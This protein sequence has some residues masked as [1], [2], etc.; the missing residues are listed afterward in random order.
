MEFLH[1]ELEVRSARV[2]M[3]V[4]DLN[5]IIPLH[6]LAQHLITTAVLPSYFYVMQT[7]LQCG[8]LNEMPNSNWSSR[9]NWF[10]RENW[11]SREHKV[12]RLCLARPC[13]TQHILL[14]IISRAYTLI[15]G[16]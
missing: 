14:D 16:T 10:S 9:E 5:T 12:W 13:G 1:P 7:Y 8:R 4:F 11:P 6:S 15:E 2:V 3:C